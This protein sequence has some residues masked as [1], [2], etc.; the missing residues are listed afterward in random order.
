MPQYSLTSAKLRLLVNG[1]DAVA[2]AVCERMAGDLGKTGTAAVCAA[3]GVKRQIPRRVERS[4]KSPRAPA[5]SRP[6]LTKE[7]ILRSALWQ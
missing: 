7:E 6:P 3:P 2:K 5:A 1:P 4:L